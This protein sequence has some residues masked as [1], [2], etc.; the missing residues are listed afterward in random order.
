M[1]RDIYQAKLIGGIF[2]FRINQTWEPEFG[3]NQTWEPELGSEQGTS[4]YISN[5]YIFAALDDFT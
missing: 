1:K 3:I 5:P 2:E 4:S